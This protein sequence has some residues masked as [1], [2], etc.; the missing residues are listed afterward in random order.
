MADSCGCAVGEGRGAGGRGSA[1]GCIGEAEAGP[2]VETAAPPAALSLRGETSE[3]LGLLE[4][5]GQRDLGLFSSWK[6]IGKAAAVETTASEANEG[7]KGDGR[8]PLSSVGRGVVVAE[9]E[10]KAGW[11]PQSEEGK[12]WGWSPPALLPA[13]EGTGAGEAGYPCGCCCCC[14]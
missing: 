13:G 2:V 8:R 11:S 12:A 14:C 3:A 5:G 6:P 4:L 1:S 10:G 9:A 7:C